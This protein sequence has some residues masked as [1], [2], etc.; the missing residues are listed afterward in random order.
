MSQTEMKPLPFKPGDLV[1]LPCVVT[2][3]SEDTATGAVSVALK[4]KEYPGQGHLFTCDA[5]LL[6]KGG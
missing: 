3:V 5:G 6:K 4:P 2:A 1:N